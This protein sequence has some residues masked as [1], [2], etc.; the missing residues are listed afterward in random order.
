MNKICLL[1]DSIFDNRMYVSRGQSVIELLDKKIKQ[2]PNSNYQSKLLAID[3]SCTRHVI[4]Q[5]QHIPKDTSHII[6]S[7]GGNDALACLNL[8]QKDVTSVAQAVDLLTRVKEDF[9]RD[10]IQ[11]L[12]GLIKLNKKLIICTIYD[13]VPGIEKRALTALA[14]YN[15]VILKEAFRYKITVIDLRL[16]FSDEGDYSKYSPIE[17]SEQG[18]LKIVEGILECIDGGELLT[19]MI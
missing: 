14:L 18:G 5:S 11:M 15:E 3:G 1:G 6:V 19:D 12:Q 17:P 4:S 2:S 9:Q 13:T 16:I 10:Y 8:M 7:T